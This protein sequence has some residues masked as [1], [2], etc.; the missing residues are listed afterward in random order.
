LRCQPRCRSRYWPFTSLL[1]LPITSRA[2]RAMNSLRRDRMG[3]APPLLNNYKF[4]QHAP[5]LL[6]KTIPQHSPFTS[7]LNLL[8]YEDVTCITRKCPWSSLDLLRDNFFTFLNFS[9][10]FSRAFDAPFKIFQ[11]PFLLPTFN[12][13]GTTYR[14]LHTT[15]RA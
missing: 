10:L 7:S 5:L 8:V 1:T 15:G 12:L 6:P 3:C 9:K 2:V 11:P 4:L 13:F 14:D